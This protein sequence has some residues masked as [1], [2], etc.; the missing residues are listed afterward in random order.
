MLPCV[1]FSE[2]DDEV[3]SLRSFST[4]MIVEAVVRCLRV[5]NNDS[6]LS[7]TLPGSMSAK[8]RVGTSL[9]NALT[10]RYL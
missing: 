8:F 7:T 10:V 5:I 1:I 9:A 6:E 4:E 3:Q 2:L